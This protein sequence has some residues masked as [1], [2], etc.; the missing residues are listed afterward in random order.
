MTL[1]TVHNKNHLIVQFIIVSIN[2]TKLHFLHEKL[3]SVATQEHLLPPITRQLLVCYYN[4]S[5]QKVCLHFGI[6]VHN[7]SALYARV[8]N[9]Q[10]ENKKNAETTPMP[11]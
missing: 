10:I 1:H 5:A 4:D 7:S 11:L 2:L 3:K 8:T 6:T 9:L